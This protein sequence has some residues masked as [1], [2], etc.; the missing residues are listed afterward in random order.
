[1]FPEELFQ[2]VLEQLADEIGA[3]GTPTRNPIQTDTYIARSVMQKAI[4]R[5]MTSLALRAAATLLAT[6]PR[7][8]WRRLV[9]IAMEDLG[10]GEGDLLARIVAASRDRAWRTKAGGDWPVI[11]S[12]IEQACAGTRC[13]SANDLRNLATHDPALDAFKDTLCDA[14]LGDLLAI[15]TDETQPVAHRGVAVLLAVGEDAGPAAPIHIRPDPGAVF[16]A[17]AQAERYGHVAVTYREAF[18]TARF[19]LAPLSLVLWSESRN[20]GMEGRDDDIPPVSWLGD[21]PTFCWDQYTRGGLTAIR[22]FAYSSPVWRD[23]AG[24]W[25]IPQADWTKAAGELLFR[26]EGAL[27]TNRRAWTTGRSLYELSGDLGCF[28]PTDAV[29]EGLTLI[30][31]ELPH[32]DRL[33]GLTH[34]TTPPATSL[35]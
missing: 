1:M 25:G 8:L 4:R 21:I 31:R 10:V 17:F 19:A 15:M 29:G 7:V 22:Q 27:L 32:I 9:V 28:M 30:V 2:F 20:A 16:E 6:D 13:T 23:F 24:R 12:L 3:R 11:T 14:A 26:A 33:R 18:K 35:L 34:P 5:G